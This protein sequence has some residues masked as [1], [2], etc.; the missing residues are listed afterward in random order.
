MN[1]DA[2]PLTLAALLVLLGLCVWALLTSGCVCLCP[3]YLWGGQPTSCCVVPGT[4]IITP[5][6]EP[7]DP[8]DP[9][10]P[11]DAGVSP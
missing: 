2:R 10:F 7:Q 5:T 1:G 9:V 4:F 6:E 3:T 11:S 8:A